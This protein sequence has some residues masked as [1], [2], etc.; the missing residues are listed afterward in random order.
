MKNQ[1]KINIIKNKL[2]NNVNTPLHNTPEIFNKKLNKSTLNT[3]EYINN[4]TG[5]TR[6]YPPAAQEWFNSIYTFNKN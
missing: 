4:D 3:L 5:K 2:L 6:H 1:V